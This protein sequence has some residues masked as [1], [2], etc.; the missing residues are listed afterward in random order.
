MESV[1][2]CLVDLAFCGDMFP[3]SAQCR[4]PSASCT[5]VSASLLV[6]ASPGMLCT[7]SPTTSWCNG[8]S[9]ISQIEFSAKSLID[10]SINF[11][12]FMEISHELLHELHPPTIAFHE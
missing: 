3:R 2:K 1:I 7:R 11:V 9:T 4:E 5:W 12:R 6:L 8:S 10:R